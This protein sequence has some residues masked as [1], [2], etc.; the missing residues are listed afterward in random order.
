ML[1]EHLLQGF[2]LNQSRLA[3]LGITE[4]QQA[5]ELLTWTLHAN[6][7]VNDTGKEVLALI[8]G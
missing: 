7:M 4:A 1:R 2:T 3:E 5:L 6:A 8:A